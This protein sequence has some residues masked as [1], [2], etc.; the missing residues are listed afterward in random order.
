MKKRENEKKR[1]AKKITLHRETL[2]QLE[3]A[4]GAAVAKP[5][6]VLTCGATC[7]GRV[8]CTCF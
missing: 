7:S 2:R 5:T 8:P 1:L 4:G 6:A 3:S